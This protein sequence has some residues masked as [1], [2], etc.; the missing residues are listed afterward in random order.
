MCD[1]EATEEDDLILIVIM[2]CESKWASV[3][4]KS[5]P[6]RGWLREVARRELSVI[7]CQNEG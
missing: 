7:S 4:T 6:I 5:K 1:I 2:V 3:A